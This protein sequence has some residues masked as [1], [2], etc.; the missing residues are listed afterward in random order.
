V[1]AAFENRR[2][3]D[4]LPD[5]H[6]RSDDVLLFLAVGS[7]GRCNAQRIKMYLWPPAMDVNALS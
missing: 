7:A 4:A 1:D 2:R 5:D 3:R 6:A